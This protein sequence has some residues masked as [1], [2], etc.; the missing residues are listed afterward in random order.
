MIKCKFFIE[1]GKFLS[2]EISGHAEYSKK[3]KDIVC[4]AVSTIAQHTARALEKE[5]AK[6]IVEDGY[7]KVLNISEDYLSQRFIN[8]L[9]E[10]LDDLSQ[11][12]PK[13]IS[14]EVNDDAH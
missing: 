2:F 13:Y 8:E 14:L 11:Q 1:N 6:V 5:G 7:L 12:Y 3:G 9:L 4:A 10:T